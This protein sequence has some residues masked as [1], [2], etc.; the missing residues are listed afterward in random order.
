MRNERNEAMIFY[1]T[2]KTISSNL[3]HFVIFALTFMF[4]LNELMLRSFFIVMYKNLWC[5]EFD[6]SVNFLHE[7]KTTQQN[8]FQSLIISHNFKTRRKTTSSSKQ[9][10]KKNNS[11]VLMMTQCSKNVFFVDFDIQQK[12]FRFSFFQKLN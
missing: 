3:F 4:S 11:I 7:R 12:R 6:R 9:D 2:K 1:L 8:N 5:F 10:E